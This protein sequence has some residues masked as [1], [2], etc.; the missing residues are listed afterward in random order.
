LPVTYGLAALGSILLPRATIVALSASSFI[1]FFKSDNKMTNTTATPVS[2][3]I[4]KDLP[5]N[6]QGPTY[7]RAKIKEGILHIGVGGFHRSHQALYLDDLFQSH[8]ELDW[9]ICGVGIMP[10]DAAMNKALQAQDCLY[11]LVER[12]G[13]KSTARIIGSLK[14]YLFGFENADASFSAHCRSCHQNCHS[15][16]Y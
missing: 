7:D 11:T 4:L 1:Y 14:T 10:Q 16:C 9:A 6:V 2:S 5:K 3:A 8:G 13:N 15:H 12:I